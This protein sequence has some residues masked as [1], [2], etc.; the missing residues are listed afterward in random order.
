[1]EYYKILRALHI[2]ILNHLGMDADSILFPTVVRRLSKYSK[3][4]LIGS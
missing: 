3:D 2:D 4:P 1:M